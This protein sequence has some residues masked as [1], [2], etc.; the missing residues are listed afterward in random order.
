MNKDNAAKAFV[1]ALNEEYGEIARLGQK[2]GQIL[3]DSRALL[4]SGGF[5]RLVDEESAVAFQKLPKKKGGK[6]GKKRTNHRD[7]RVIPGHRI[8][9]LYDS[10]SES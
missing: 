4:P 3:L 10:L 5:R 7:R 2:S 9:K 6:A 8:H 1:S